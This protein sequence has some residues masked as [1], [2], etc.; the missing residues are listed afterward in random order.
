MLA[1]YAAEWVT[2]VASF[3]VQA[4]GVIH[5]NPKSTFLIRDLF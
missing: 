5:P 1:Y 2:V 4:S 3:I